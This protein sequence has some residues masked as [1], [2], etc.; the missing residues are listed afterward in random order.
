M[1]E[2]GLRWFKHF[3]SLLSHAVWNLKNSPQQASLSLAWVVCAEKFAERERK[4]CR[5]E[6]N[7]NHRKISNSTATQRFSPRLLLLNYVIC[8]NT[9]PQSL[10]HRTHMILSSS[11]SFFAQRMAEKEYHTRRWLYRKARS[12]IKAF[13][14]GVIHFESTI[15]RDMRERREWEKNMEYRFWS[16]CKSKSWNDYNFSHFNWLLVI[17]NDELLVTLSCSIQFT[18]CC[19]FTLTKNT[20]DIQYFD[21]SRVAA[22]FGNLSMSR[23]EI[24][25][26]SIMI[27]IHWLLSHRDNNVHVSRKKHRT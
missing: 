16:N 10:H 17:G 12:E 15:P 19:C 3:I 11:S 23:L 8:H 22:R 9:W 14:A 6:K 2:A 25:I 20:A 26:K 7:K 13:S 27:Y 24:I 18:V 4:N 1:S 5:T 21:E